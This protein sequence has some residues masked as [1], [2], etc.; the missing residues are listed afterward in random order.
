LCVPVLSHHLCPRD[1][2]AASNVSCRFACR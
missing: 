2:D 1:L